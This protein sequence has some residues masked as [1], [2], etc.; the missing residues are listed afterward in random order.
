MINAIQKFKESVAPEKTRIAS[1][2]P[3]ILVFGGPASITDKYTSCRNVFLSWAHE[4]KYELANF[5]RIP[6]N[7]PEW[8]NFEGYSNLVDFEKDAGC[9]TRGILLFSE[10]PGALA[11]LGAFCTDEILCE[12]LLVVLAHEYYDVPSFISLG[13][14]KRIEYKHTEKAICVVNT[15][16]DAQ[17]FEAEVEDV[18]KAL[19]DKVGTLPKTKQFDA[20]E[21]RDQFLLIADLVGL[22]GA[23]TETELGILLKFMGVD[24]VNLKRMLGQLTLFELIIK[25]P[26][27]TERYY[28]P[29][30]QRIEFLNYTA[31]T[32][33]KFERATFKL[34]SVNPELKKDRNRFNAYTKI[35]GVPSWI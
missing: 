16:K 33:S 11:E 24:P 8:N 2:F 9:L 27:K 34:F 15:T 22:F 20:N 21:T 10:R 4:T 17:I 32:A 3:L 7:F 30:K 29:P 14:I 13:P 25:S 26:E 35:H 19:R 5:L 6:E 18:G 28:V 1:L 12:R 31:P 23:L